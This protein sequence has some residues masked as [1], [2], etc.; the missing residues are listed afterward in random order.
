M[1]LLIFATTV[2]QG[3]I[4]TAEPAVEGDSLDVT[5]P[6]HPTVKDKLM[7]APQNIPSA[8]SDTLKLVVLVVIVGLV[9]FTIRGFRAR[10]RARLLEKSEV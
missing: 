10:R 8:A 1:K 4:G 7:M 5:V 3:L 9:F 6:I 2:L